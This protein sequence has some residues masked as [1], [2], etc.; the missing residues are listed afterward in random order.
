VSGEGA[1][2]CPTSGGGHV[3]PLRA[4]ALRGAPPPPGRPPRFPQAGSTRR[5]GT[6]MA[7]PAESGRGPSSVPGILLP[8]KITVKGAPCGRVSDGAKTAPPLSVILPGKISA[9]IGRT[10]QS[11]VP[12]S[13]ARTE[14]PG[15]M[16]ITRW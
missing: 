8:L 7:A 1:G 14:L 5:Y 15:S 9:P 12:A 3:A 11:E 6:P 2:H 16:A 13:V 10:G 4:E